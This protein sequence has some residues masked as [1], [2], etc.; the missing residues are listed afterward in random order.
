M[1]KSFLFMWQECTVAPHIC[2]FCLMRWGSPHKRGRPVNALKKKSPNKRKKLRLCGDA[3]TRLC[4]A[5]NRQSFFKKRIV[6]VA[7]CGKSV[8]EQKVFVLISIPIN[9]IYFDVT[10]ASRPDRDKIMIN[11]DVVSDTLN[12]QSVRFLLSLDA[13]PFSLTQ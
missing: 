2:N 11:A 5:Y 7:R 9:C 13:G 4:K 10:T 6:M 1:A 3:A 12:L 8:H